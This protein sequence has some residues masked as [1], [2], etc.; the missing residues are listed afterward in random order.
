M[1]KPLTPSKKNIPKPDF[2]ELKSK[3]SQEVDTGKPVGKEVW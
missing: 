3:F 1:K 2:N